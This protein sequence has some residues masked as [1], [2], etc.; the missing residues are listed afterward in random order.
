MTAFLDQVMIKATFGTR[1]IAKMPD[2]RFAQIAGKAHLIPQLSNAGL[3]SRCNLRADCAQS[4]IAARLR[5][6]HK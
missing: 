5:A 4:Q 3:D 1:K 2:V 6:C